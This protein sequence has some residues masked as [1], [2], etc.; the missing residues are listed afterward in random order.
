MHRRSAPRGR[1]RSPPRR[2]YDRDERDRGRDRERERDRDRDR[3]R[4]RGSERER[5]RRERERESGRR[6][7]DRDRDRG[8]N[9]DGRQRERERERARDAQRRRSP[10]PERRRPARSI[11]ESRYDSLF[12]GASWYNGLGD[13]A[14]AAEAPAPA[15]AAEP[16]ASAPAPAP[17]PAADEPPQDVEALKSSL[18]AGLLSRW[19]PPPPSQAPAPAPPQPAPAPQPPAQA[20][21]A[22]IAA[23][24][25]AVAAAA[26]TPAS[27]PAAACNGD[28]TARE[29][30]GD[31]EG[32]DDGEG[33][34]GIPDHVFESVMRQMDEEF[35]TPDERA[36]A[37]ANAA[38]A[39][40]RARNPR[41]RRLRLA[42]MSCA[43]VLTALRRLGM[44]E[45]AAAFER[46]GVTGD[47]C[48]LLDDELLR[49]SLG[50]VRG[51]QR[52]AF[53]GWVR[54]MQLPEQRPVA[55][56]RVTAGAGARA[57]PPACSSSGP[58]SYGYLGGGASNI[59]DGGSAGRIILGGR[60]CSASAINLRLSLAQGAARRD[61]THGQGDAPGRNP[62]PSTDGLS[63]TS[64]SG[65]P[66]PRPPPDK[67]PTRLPTA[68]AADPD[69][70][71]AAPM[72]D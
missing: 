20:A 28:A 45:H 40:A 35:A 44:G 10:S 51:E 5:D 61:P 12:E 63:S 23:P 62:P 39:A 43:H 50:V 58:T 11:I 69:R 27:T 16:S 17:A 32:D 42:E 64:E 24:S 25:A 9:K 49:R 1:D 30:D 65:P 71:E 48:D 4:D 38:N 15:A 18:L 8:S 57:A 47:M 56:R 60:V 59:F 52:L 3:E 72:V 34:G 31:G 41:G 14:P 70:G 36:I 33:E 53:L 22:P 19:E 6:E 46:G 29:G 66:P 54:G 7:G 55:W 2:D 68:D 26:A 37:A 21:A 13:G 67:P